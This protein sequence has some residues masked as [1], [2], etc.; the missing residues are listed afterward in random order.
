MLMTT[1][2]LHQTTLDG[3]FTSQQQVAPFSMQGLMDHLV[4]LII[5]EDD[6]FLLLDKPVF[7]HLLHYLRPSL[8]LNDIPHRTKVCGKVLVRAVE[9]ESKVKAALQVCLMFV[10]HVKR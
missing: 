3:T 8:R 6:A 10:C 2:S 5:S 1:S 9:A 7:R 4:E